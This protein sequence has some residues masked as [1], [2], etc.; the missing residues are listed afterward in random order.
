MRA[1]LSRELNTR[2]ISIGIQSAIRN[3]VSCTQLSPQ[4][5]MSRYEAGN[6]PYLIPDTQVLRNKLGI[7]DSFALQ[8]A[9]H[10]AAFQAAKDI[11]LFAPPFTFH[12]LCDL[13]RRLFSQVYEWAGQ[14]RTIP[15]SKGSSRFAQP[16]FIKRECEKVYTNLNFV[17]AEVSRDEDSV[18]TMLASA[19]ADLNVAHPFR[20]GNGRSIRMHLEHVAFHLDYLINW[21]SVNQAQWV[22][23]SIES[24]SDESSLV[25]WF[26][27]HLIDISPILDE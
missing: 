3:V 9:E 10:E 6:D 13:H 7:S 25:Y 2:I 20:D 22:K 17:F 19:Y 21:Q 1:Q 16:E 24:M 18:G 8:E 27:K 12:Q 26:S 15:M 14:E 4:I 11:Q 23:M 5:L